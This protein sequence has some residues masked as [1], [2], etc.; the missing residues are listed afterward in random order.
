MSS[1]DHSNYVDWESLNDSYDIFYVLSTFAD[2]NE[3]MD[4]EYLLQ[5]CCFDCL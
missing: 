1:T 2:T 3:G 5:K 4:N